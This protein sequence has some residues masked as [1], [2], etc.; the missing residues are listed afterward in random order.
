MTSEEG[1]G[2]SCARIEIEP[3]TGLG[4]YLGCTQVEGTAVNGGANVSTMTYDMEEF[5]EMSVQKCKHIDGEH[6]KVKDAKT[7][8]LSAD[9][10]DHQA[11]NP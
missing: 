10:K 1:T 7:S 11:G 9:A 5:L 2:S 8:S 3:E 6:V 4:L